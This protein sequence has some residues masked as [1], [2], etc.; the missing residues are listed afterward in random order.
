M[1]WARW[2][3]L[4]GMNIWST[5]RLH[6]LVAFRHAHFCLCGG[7][8]QEKGA[9]GVFPDKGKTIEGNPVV[10]RKKIEKKENFWNPYGKAFKTKSESQGKLKLS[11]LD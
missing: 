3:L 2:V 1:H 10:Q 7:Q 8:K 6:T 11:W 9:A 5:L 4:Y